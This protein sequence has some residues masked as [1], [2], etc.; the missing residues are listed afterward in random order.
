[1]EEVQAYTQEKDECGHCQQIYAFNLFQTG[2]LRCKEEGENQTIITCSVCTSVSFRVCPSLW[3]HTYPYLVVGTIS[4][5][6]VHHIYL[7]YTQT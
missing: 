5:D 7:K 2:W 4:E 1:M 3:T 6:Y